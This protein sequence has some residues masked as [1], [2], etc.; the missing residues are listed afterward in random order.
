MVFAQNTRNLISF[1]LDYR[2]YP[3]DIEDVPRG[4]LPRNNGLPPNDEKFWQTFSVHSEF[5]LQIQKNW[6]FSASLYGRYNLLHRIENVN[7]TSPYPT[8]LGPPL[9]KS[10]EKKNLKFDFFLDVEKKIRLK[11][12]NQQFLFIKGG[13]GFTNINSRFDIILTD[14]LESVPFDTKHYK[15]TFFHFGPRL[16][17]GY[18]YNKI[19]ASIDG[20]IIEDPMLT[21]LTSMWLGA[22]LSY[23]IKLKRKK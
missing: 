6:V 14:S 11:K 9:K 16:S 7:Y 4:P 19:K 18:Q 21:N 13:A 2:I 23:E 8:V 3:I 5:G 15:G 17:I 10:K 22:S 12:N 1:G 20:Y